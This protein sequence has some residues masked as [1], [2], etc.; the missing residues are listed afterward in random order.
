MS[1]LIE[2]RNHGMRIAQR[3]SCIMDPETPLPFSGEPNP[4]YFIHS[5]PHAAPCHHPPHQPGS[6]HGVACEEEN[7]DGDGE[8]KKK[9]IAQQNGEKNGTEKVWRESNGGGVMEEEPRE[10]QVQ[11]AYLCECSIG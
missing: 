8:N 11:P 1:P 3:F 7:L 6:G 10:K 5:T 2:V 9:K 4:W